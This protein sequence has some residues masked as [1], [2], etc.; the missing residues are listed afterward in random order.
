M[1]HVDKMRGKG[2][3][4]CLWAV[5]IIAA[6]CFWGIGYPS[7]LAW[8]EQFQLFLFDGSYLMERLAVPGGLSAYVAECLV[9][10]Y[11]YPLA[12]AA[13][14]ALLY[15]AMQGLVWKLMRRQAGCGKARGSWLLFVGSFLP[16]LVL[17][18]LMG[19]A[20]VMLAYTISWLCVLGGMLLYPSGRRWRWLYGLLVFPVVYWM[21]G[22]LVLVLALYG[23]LKEI[24]T[25]RLKGLGFGI[26]IGWLAYVC[27]CIYVSGWFEPYPLRRLFGGLFYYSYPDILSLPL[28]W[29]VVVIGVLLLMA[30]WMERWAGR[31]KKP[32]WMAGGM[33]L[34][35]LAGFLGLAHRQY[36]KEALELI[37]YD[38]LVR[39]Q[40]WDDII[41]KAEQRHPDVPMSVC[42]VNLALGMN[43][44]LDDRAF[45]FF[46]NGPQGLFPK[47]VRD[48]NTTLLTGEVYFYL[49]LVNTAQRYA[50]EAMEAI[51]NYNKSGRAV[52]RL[53]ETN[54]INGQYKVAEKYLKML[55]KTLFYRQWAQN[56]MEMV[57]DTG[58]ID[59]HPVYGAMRKKRLKEDFLFSDRELDKICGQLLMH[60]KDNGLARQYLLA[61]P[62]LNCDL[63]TFM[64][65]YRYVNSLA[66]Y[67]PKACQE[68]AA[69]AYVIQKMQVPRG[70]INPVVMK[71]LEQFA[72]FYTYSG[73]R[74]PQLEAFK[75]TYWY[76]FMNKQQ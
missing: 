35:I 25:A 39:M 24:R 73:K 8:Q 18:L 11:K 38:Y 44:Q 47:F 21:A 55:E 59:R 67:Q 16:P 19:D 49:G 10:F 40:R 15:G 64:Q 34:V 74:S 57:A 32:A 6:Y 41:H 14:V 23:L 63:G 4:A 75:G 48:H 51:P 37:D 60:D 62:L 30:G 3:R 29:P 36:T 50:F 56:R 66:A 46:Q 70:M 20:N 61:Y 53:A 2:C 33:C 71:R 1:I 68:A 13:V 54:L 22:P 31:M 43:N 69:F 58:L 65:Y 5:F 27:L 9:Q 72:R 45:E 28:G 42:A 17:W 76:Y 12:G 26:G 7:V 52:Q